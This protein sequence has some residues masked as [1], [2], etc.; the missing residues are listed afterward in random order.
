MEELVTGKSLTLISVS[1]LTALLLQ[2]RVCAL[3]PRSC[4]RD[5]GW[6]HMCVDIM[7]LLR[8]FAWDEA[9]NERS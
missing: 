3:P 2:T 7:T 8:S 4:V 1:Q 6:L 5:V 9:E